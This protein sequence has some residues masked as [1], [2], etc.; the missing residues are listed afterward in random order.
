MIVEMPNTTVSKIS[1]QLQELR[2]QG[3]VVALGR[4]L[5]LLIQTEFRHIESAL[6][7][8]NGASRLHPSRII[9]LAENSDDASSEPRLDAQIRVGGDAGASEVIVLW[10]HGAAASSPDSLVMG[11]LLP[12]AP[13]VAWWPHS[14][15]DNPAATPFGRIASRRI[16]D[17]AEAANPQRY[18]A[19]LARNYQPGDGDMAW[20]R[21]TL[22][23]GQL[24][25]L[26]Q[27]HLNRKVV[28]VEVIGNENSP[29]ADLLAKWL[30]QALG[31]GVSLLRTYAGEEVQGIAGVRM[32]ST[33]RW[34]GPMLLAMFA[35]MVLV[36]AFPQLALWLPHKLGY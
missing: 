21:L 9:L 18:L 14:A 25:A 32:E 36:I 1:K 33:V 29:S 22:W 3:G 16:T 5:T 11:L 12:D 8:A 10:A 4:V 35:V 13:V 34:V 30:D 31:A 26:F 19:A 7:A 15:P 17:S 27:Q 6:Q 23:R 20:T 24:A 28:G 2:D